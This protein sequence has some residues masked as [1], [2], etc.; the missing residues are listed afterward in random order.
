ME[1]LDSNKLES[2]YISG[3]GGKHYA[4]ETIVGV[5]CKQQL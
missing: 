4:I 5:L 2:E 3:K 1:Q